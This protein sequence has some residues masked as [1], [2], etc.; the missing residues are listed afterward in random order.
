MSDPT[1]HARLDIGI[2]TGVT[3]EEFAWLQES[4]WE[5][6]RELEPLGVRTGTNLSGRGPGPGEYI[7]IIS[8]IS[9]TAASLVA[10]AQAVITWRR[11]VQQRKVETTITLYVRGK[12]HLDLNIATDEQIHVYIIELR[13]DAPTTTDLR[14]TSPRPE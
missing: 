9:G 8:G 2:G 3:R 1:Q 13:G 14:I 6:L 11:K 10:I 5:M 12:E 4:V 7:A